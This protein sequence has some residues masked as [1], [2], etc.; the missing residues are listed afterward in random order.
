MKKNIS[1]LI[2]T[3]ND[4]TMTNFDRNEITDEDM[5]LTMVHLALMLNDNGVDVSYVLDGIMEVI[6]DENSPTYEVFS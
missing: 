6:D 4:S 2:D 3:D 1:V 5:I